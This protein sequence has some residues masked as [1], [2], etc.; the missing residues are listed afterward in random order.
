MLLK[1]A[2]LFMAF[3]M[4]LMFATLFDRKSLLEMPTA[5]LIGIGI[6]LGSI[7][8]LHPLFTKLREYVKV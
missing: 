7:L 1:G 6:A 2:S 4:L 8:T 3:S 5:I